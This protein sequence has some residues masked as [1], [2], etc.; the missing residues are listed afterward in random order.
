MSSF[1]I[2]NKHYKMI[3]F[4]ITTGTLIFFV[5]WIG[6]LAYKYHLET[7]ERRIL[8]KTD[9][10]QKARELNSQVHEEIEKLKKENEHLK[11]A[12]YEFI[13]DN[14]EKEYY[15]L[16]THKLVK[17]I[18]KDNTIWEYDKNNGLLLKKIDRY[19]NIEEYGIHGKLIKKTLSDG[20]W[21]E[22]NPVN[23]KLMKRKN[24]DN[25]IEEFD[26]NEEKFKEID[27]NGKVK[28]F[29]T[30]LYQNISDFKKLNFTIRQLKDIGFS[31]QELKDAGYTLE[32]FISAGY[33]EKELKDAGYTE[34]E[35]DKLTTEQEIVYH[36]DRKTIAHIKIFYSKTKKEIKRIIYS[37]D[38]KTI[39][40]INEFNPEGKIIKK[41]YYNPDGTVKKIETY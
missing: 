2:G 12:P 13:R 25:S 33:T 22:Y 32:Q 18:D 40:W 3:P 8:L 23:E 34:K 30:K 27:K 10:E 35:I 38:G 21:M 14:G 5:F 11:N 37:S 28:Y 41:T 31:L 4:L 24:I 6:G 29:K 19:K 7:E 16:F 9:I 39:D 20:V 1:R 36:T 26:D 17:K 15:N